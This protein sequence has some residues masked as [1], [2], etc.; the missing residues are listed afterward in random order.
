MA[1]AHSTSR[2]VSVIQLPLADPTPGIFTI[3]KLSFV[4][5]VKL[6]VVENIVK[7]VFIVGVSPTSIIA[8]VLPFPPE[9]GRLYAVFIWLGE[10][11][12]G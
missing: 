6:N 3:S 1:C 10:I 4:G 2:Q 9:G 12:K 5:I 11:P 7:S 8:I